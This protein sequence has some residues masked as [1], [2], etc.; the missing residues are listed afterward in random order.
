MSA[1]RI[2]SKKK[3][4]TTPIPDVVESDSEG[5]VFLPG[6]SALMITESRAG[7]RAVTPDTPKRIEYLANLGIAIWGEDN[8]LPNRAYEAGKASTIIGGENGIPFLIRA[9]YGEGLRY[10]REQYDPV[11]KEFYIDQQPIPEFQ[12]IL[13]HPATQAAIQQAIHDHFWYRNRFPRMIFSRN[14]RKV[15][16][17]F[18]NKAVDS[19]WG[20]QNDRG[21]IEK[22][23]LNANWDLLAGAGTEHEETIELPVINS[24]DF[25]AA[26]DV[27]DDD[28]HFDYVF[29]SQDPSNTHYY[30]LA[31][32]H[33]AIESGWYDVAMA[34]P[35]FKKFLMA[36]QMTIKYIITVPDWW[37]EEQAGGT[38]TWN[39]MTREEKQEFRRD[40]QREINSFLSGLENSGKSFMTS[41]K[42]KDKNQALAKPLEGLRIKLIE[43][44][45]FSGEYLGDSAEASTHIMWALG[46]DPRLIGDAPGSNRSGGAGSDK[47][48][49]F[50][51]FLNLCKSYAD[52]ILEPLI[53]AAR[54]NG[55]DPD[56]NLKV[57]FN[58][59][60]FRAKSETTPSQRNT[61][62]SEQKP[63]QKPGPKPADTDED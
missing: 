44:Q 38:E 24:H 55:L 5:L 15:L 48:E 39:K 62:P 61:V 59:P 57:W 18:P 26:E 4:S 19:R 23:F 12:K 35:K 43:Q 28:N 7:G 22:C 31:P 8:K 41:E 56:Y 54:Y 32:W 13:N 27:L 42:T 40:K 50:N 29:R 52:S 20:L 21:L 11:T 36:N 14:K 49:A 63:P 9:I 17:L 6:A 25:L 58:R 3:K 37:W 2:M 53:W 10:G 30:S 60:F 34:I 1:F 33:S 46:I 16:Y 51:I 47:E 45:T